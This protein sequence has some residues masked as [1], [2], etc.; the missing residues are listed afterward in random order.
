M[1]PA[2]SESGEQLVSDGM[3]NVEEAARFLGLSRSSIY[4]LME[5]GQLPYAKFGK[6]RR[7]PRKALI[8]LAAANL[9]GVS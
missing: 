8:E 1:A 7:I 4:G 5:S 6:A 9:R 3:V 2:T